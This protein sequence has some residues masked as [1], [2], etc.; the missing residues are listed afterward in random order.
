MKQ[1]IKITENELLKLGFE[2][3]DVDLFELQLTKI[4][5]PKLIDV[6]LWARAEGGLIITLGISE[7]DDPQQTDTQLHHIKHVHELQNL[8]FALTGTNLFYQAES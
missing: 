3:S 4:R 8:Y 5:T 2:Q 6:S 1:N 7:G